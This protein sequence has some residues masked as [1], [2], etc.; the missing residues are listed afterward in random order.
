MSVLPLSQ[1]LTRSRCACVDTW[2]A[3]GTVSDPNTAAEGNPNAG[4]WQPVWDAWQR[5]VEP[6]VSQAWAPPALPRSAAQIPAWTCRSGWCWTYLAVSGQLQ[7]R[8]QTAQGTTRRCPH[9]HLAVALRRVTAELDSQHYNVTRSKL[10][11]H[12]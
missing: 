1:V 2:Y 7:A 10:R 11:K 12:A 8:F 4:S 5:F 9:Q 6:L 3:N